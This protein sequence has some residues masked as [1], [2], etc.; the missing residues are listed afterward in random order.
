MPTTNWNDL[1]DRLKH[2]CIAK[3]D[4]RTRFLFRS[5]SRR[6]RKLVDM[7]KFH[8][9]RV[10]I[11]ETHGLPFGSVCLIPHNSSTIHVE[12]FDLKFHKN[13]MIPLI[14]YI[15]KAAIIDDL[16]VFAWRNEELKEK[17][18]R[19]VFEIPRES[20]NWN[21]LSDFVKFRKTARAERFLV[22]SEPVHFDFI[23]IKG[24]STIC[25][26]ECCEF[27]FRTPG[28]LE[29]VRKFKNP[30]EFKT[31][32]FPFLKYILKIG[33]IDLFWTRTAVMYIDELVSEFL[34]NFAGISKFRIKSLD[35]E[36]SRK[37]MFFFIWNCREKFLE[38]IKT[39]TV[40][41]RTFP[42]DKFLRY[43]SVHN[44]RRIEISNAWDIKI[45]CRIIEKWLEIDAQL[46]A[47]VIV[48]NTGSLD[49]LVEHFE[50]SL[51]PQS[52]KIL[53]KTNNPDKQILVIPE[54]VDTIGY[55]G[56]CTCKVV[57]TEF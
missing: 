22:D 57:R 37:G 43:P 39:S 55:L 13:T 32:I 12:C 17:L 14:R 25:R 56:R 40:L 35:F 10:I 54:D 50:D 52:D 21:H 28:H 29:T 34:E 36:M 3:M 46:G 1:S 31:K 11:T 38:S 33:I 42:I 41:H 48:H 26:S 27:T 15:E 4:F 51:A 2:K 24:G 20:K 23:Q 47:T 53:L 16:E 8:F 45:L 19:G 49:R 6:D 5:V 7:H 44:A 30:V 9:E 18:V